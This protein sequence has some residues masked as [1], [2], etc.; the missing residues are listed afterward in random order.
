MS[1]TLHAHV[2]ELANAARY[3]GGNERCRPSPLSALSSH[4]MAQSPLYAPTLSS[5][6]PPSPSPPAPASIPASPVRASPRKSENQSGQEGEVGGALSPFRLPCLPL[7]LLHF[8]T[9][10]SFSP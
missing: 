2:H 5:C 4:Y 3:M 6:F 9:C 1:G 8:A 7:P 10:D